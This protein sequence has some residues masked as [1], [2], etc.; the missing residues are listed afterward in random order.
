[1]SAGWAWRVQA[2]V[3]SGVCGWSTRVDRLNRGTA[4]STAEWLAERYP[5]WEIRLLDDATGE[6]VH[7]A[8]VSA[9]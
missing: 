1:M 7:V 9:P 5:E 8:K 4:D 6:I 2:R 3:P